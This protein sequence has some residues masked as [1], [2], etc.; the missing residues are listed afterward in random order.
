MR[1]VNIGIVGVG[2]VGTGTLT[3]LAD[4]AE[5]IAQKCGFRL[6]VKAVCS[7]T[8]EAKPLPAALGD[9]VVK[10]TDWREVVSHPEIDIV[11]ELIGGTHVAREVLEGA[12]DHG[13]SVV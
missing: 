1:Q 10:T 2:N 9:S 13:K 4:N 8:I 6:A 7:R 11:A 12:I 5:S 3:I